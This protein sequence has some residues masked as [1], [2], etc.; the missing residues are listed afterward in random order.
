[1]END[2]R[3]QTSK[4]PKILNLDI[5]ISQLIDCASREHKQWSNRTSF[6]DISNLIVLAKT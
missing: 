6:L 5:K 3:L 2:K 1:M 4:V